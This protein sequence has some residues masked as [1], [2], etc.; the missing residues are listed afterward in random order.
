[1]ITIGVRRAGYAVA[2]ASALALAVTGCGAD[3]SDAADDGTI[4][5][6]TSTDAWGSVVKA[7]G[8]DQ[9]SV[10]SI[11][12]AS[13]GDPHSYESTAR[14]GIAFADAKLVLYNG[15]GYD[16][17]ATQLAEQAAEA[18]V[19]NAVELS[20]HEG[21]DEEGADE[22]AG[23]GAEHGDEGSGD[24]HATEGDEHGH[25]HHDGFNE[26]VWYDLHTVAS[27]ADAVAHELAEIKPAEAKT[28]EANAKEFTAGLEDLEAKLA[29]IGEDNP[30]AK[31]IATEPVAHYMLEAAGLTDVTPD[32][33]RDAIENQT[34]V[35]VLVQDEVLSKV[36]DG[37]VAA[38]VNNPLTQTP[39]TERLVETAKQADIP[40]V[41]ITPT[42]PADDTSYLDWVNAEADALRAAVSG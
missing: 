13:D 17:F 15:G 21:G 26:H 14:D 27:V 2:T 12:D 6:V 16:D 5:V 9:V 36:T 32:D 4:P 23:E 20:G 10:T 7:I 1:M 41:D 31:V 37:D 29:A 34:D 18:P 24:E 39:I 38:V 40:V 25:D 28:F 35:P 11:I 22:H 42:L 8:G 3:A 33:Y 19:L 30:D